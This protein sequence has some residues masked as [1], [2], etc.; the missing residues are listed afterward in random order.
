VN[1]AIEEKDLGQ[2][3]PAWIARISLSDADACFSYS[4]GTIIE[5][6]I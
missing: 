6:Q 3:V 2:P 1:E 5:N 4:C